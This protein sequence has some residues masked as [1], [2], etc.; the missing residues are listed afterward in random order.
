VLIAI[1]GPSASGKGTIAHGLAEHYHLDYL[2]TGLLYRRSAME[3][4]KAGI[5]LEDEA[6]LRKLIE[7]I[8]WMQKPDSKTMTTLMQE[9]IGQ[10]A[11]KVASYPEVRAAL[12]TTQKNFARR[13]QGAILD[14]RDI[15]TV[16]CPDADHKLF[17]TANHEVRAKRRYLQL[18]PKHP[19][20]TFDDVLEQIRRRD[21]RDQS[22]AV[23]PLVAAPDALTLN[24]T[25]MKVDE[26][27]QKAINW[28]DLRRQ[29]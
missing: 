4:Q 15:G 24:T 25:Q 8:D 9:D 3:A 14:G 23:A 18:S 26:A 20:L 1:D 10:A 12:L 16:I 29:D 28:I 6:T 2:N 21:I 17:V 13:P 19:D 5:S 22:R 27:L 11:S 7:E